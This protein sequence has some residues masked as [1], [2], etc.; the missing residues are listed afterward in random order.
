M[1]VLTAV[2]LIASASAGALGVRKATSLAISSSVDVPFRGIPTARVSWSEAHSGTQHVAEGR[3][4]VVMLLLDLTASMHRFTNKFRG[5]VY[6]NDDTALPDSPTLKSN[7]LR[8][9]VDQF[10]NAVRPGERF[11]VSTFREHVE[12]DLDFTADRDAV[13]K[14]GRKLLDIPDSD[15]TR[16]G[17]SPIWDAVNAAVEGLKPLPGR[18]SVILV[19]DGNASGNHIGVDDAAHRAA[20][21]GIVI[22][23]IDVLPDYDLRQADGSTITIRPS[24]FV[25]R[26]AAT[27]G[28]TFLV[29]RDDDW[30]PKQLNALLT[31]LR[32][33]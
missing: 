32:R 6:R 7:E 23:V 17:P 12:L 2:V 18:R 25:Q 33:R 1:V 26:L 20:T 16:Y 5:S 10:A 3:N 29:H 14:A 24:V 8:E 21:A 27:T 11:S 28:G 9:L 19:T 15:V 30:I 13:R 31:E 4:L 22:N